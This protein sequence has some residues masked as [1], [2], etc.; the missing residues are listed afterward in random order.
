MLTGAMCVIL[1]VFAMLD[2]QV[3]SIIGR[4]SPSGIGPDGPLF[5][6]ADLKALAGIP[7]A[8]SKLLAVVHDKDTSAD[9]RFVAAE[10]LL[11]GG[12][13]NWRSKRE[14]RH[15]VADVL[16]DAL[17]RDRVHNRW[18]LPGEFT[19]RFGKQLLGLQAE[20]D[21]ALRR[22]LND[23]RPLEIAGSE[24]ATLNSKARYRV[25]DLAAWLL[26][27]TYGVPWSNNPDP[28][29]RDAEIARL[30]DMPYPKGK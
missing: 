6:E 26:I 27:S 17:V 29:V 24:A 10:A 5:H 12:W 7:S 28:A 16:A 9:H 25:S 20:G 11:E 1:A 2:P 23:N 30:R 13:T 18:G 14:D 19:G 22:L 8:E 21:A 15:A 4:V 3:L